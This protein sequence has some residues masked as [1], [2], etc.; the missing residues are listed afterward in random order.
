MIAFLKNDVNIPKLIQIY[1]S[2]RAVLVKFDV[3]FMFRL[4]VRELTVKR[5][6]SLKFQ[7]HYAKSTYLFLIYV[8]FGFIQ[9]EKFYP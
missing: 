2:K 4:P 5:C 3:Q 1:S 7:T 9:T 8:D 6:I